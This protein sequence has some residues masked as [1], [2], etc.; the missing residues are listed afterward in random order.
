MKKQPKRRETLQ[1]DYVSNQRLDM[2]L[3]YIE[4]EIRKLEVRKD[5]LEQMSERLIAKHDL[6][7]RYSYSQF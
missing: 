4:S 7:E 3:E 5:E 1:S 6:L 2:A